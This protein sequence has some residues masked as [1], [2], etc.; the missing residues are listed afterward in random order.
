M[1]QRMLRAAQLDINLY[2]EVEHDTTLT[3][4]ALQVVILVAIIGGIGAFVA[5]LIGPPQIAIEGV[6]APRGGVV[7][8][9]IRFILHVIVAVIGWGVWAWLTY[10]IGTRLFGGTATW[11]ELLRTL[12]YA[13]APGVLAIFQ[14]IPIVCLTALILLAA[15]IWQIVTGVVAVRQALDFDTGKAILTI[16]I[17]I[18]PYIIIMGVI[19]ALSSLITRPFV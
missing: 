5:G 14:F 9:I 8:G 6:P 17:A 4:Q 10:F 2:E 18:I 15:F 7:P 19:S 16:V 12:G 11:G 13:S 3:N 1:I